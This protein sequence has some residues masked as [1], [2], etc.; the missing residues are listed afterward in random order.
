MNVFRGQDGSAG[1][2][3]HELGDLAVCNEAIALLALRLVF[4]GLRGRL[5]ADGLSGYRALGCPFRL[6]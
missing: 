1:A 2:V 6:P 4:M 3:E 5:I